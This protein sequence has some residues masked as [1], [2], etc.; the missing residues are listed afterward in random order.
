MGNFADAAARLSALSL[1]HRQTKEATEASSPEKIREHA[2]RVG[3]PA[4]E[5][6]L[7]ADTV[8]VGPDPTA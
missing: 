8:I 3:M 1:P 7:A 6:T 4:D 5:I 2:T